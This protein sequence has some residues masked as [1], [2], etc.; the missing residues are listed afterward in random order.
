MEI[1]LKE[2]KALFGGT[3]KKV[4]NTEWLNIPNKNTMATI[5]DWGSDGCVLRFFTYKNKPRHFLCSGGGHRGVHHMWCIH[6]DEDLEGMNTPT[7]HNFI[8]ETIH[9]MNDRVMDNG[10]TDGN[11][12]NEYEHFWE[13][14]YAP[15]MKQQKVAP[16]VHWPIRDHRLPT[17]IRLYIETITNPAG[18]ADLLQPLASL[19][20]FFQRWDHGFAGFHTECLTKASENADVFVDG[21]GYYLT[22]HQKAKTI[23]LYRTV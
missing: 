20:E 4:N 15:F 12:K 9:L 21:K 5:H 11:P 19:F 14:I 22:V 8:K 23:T 7:A 3:V 6:P 18:K 13:E 16:I 10:F 17:H 1:T 2:I